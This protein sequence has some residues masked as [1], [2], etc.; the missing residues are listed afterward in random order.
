LIALCL[1]QFERAHRY[2]D[3]AIA[4]REGTGSF[5]SW[6]SIDATIRRMAV[7]RQ[8]FKPSEHNF[9]GGSLRLDPPSTLGTLLIGAIHSMRAAFSGP[10][11]FEE[12]IFELLKS[13]VDC[14][15]AQLQNEPGAVEQNV[16]QIRVG[17]RYVVF[18]GLAAE[19][20]PIVEQELA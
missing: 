8:L 17:S 19:R 5:Q 3:L 18:Y 1:G 6:A 20:L 16:C 11:A 12:H 7:R 15:A 14:P 9:F 2:I 4:H 13:H 10:G